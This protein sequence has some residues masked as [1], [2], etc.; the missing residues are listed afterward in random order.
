MCW[1]EEGIT[2]KGFHKKKKGVRLDQ[3]QVFPKKEPREFAFPVV[4]PTGRVKKS[5]G[6]GRGKGEKGGQA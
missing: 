1:G 2:E 5:L 4:K 6:R 3:D